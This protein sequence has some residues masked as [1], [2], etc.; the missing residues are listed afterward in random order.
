M[1]FPANPEVL[2][3]EAMDEV[4]GAGSPKLIE[5]VCDGVVFPSTHTATATRRNPPPDSFS[6]NFAKIEDS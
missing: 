2:R 5:S 4:Q 6:I 3:D 1:T